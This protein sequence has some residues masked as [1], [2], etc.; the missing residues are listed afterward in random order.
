ATKA[1]E[2]AGAVAE[3]AASRLDTAGKQRDA[4]SAAVHQL[5]VALD[6]AITDLEAEDQQFELVTQEQD[7]AEA[8]LHEAARRLADA[9]AALQ[10]MAP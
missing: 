5:R 7:A 9:E 2:R 10:S 3:R 8:K 4:A 1:V 6:E